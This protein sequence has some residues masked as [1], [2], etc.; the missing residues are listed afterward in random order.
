MVRPRLMLC[1]AAI[2]VALLGVGCVEASSSPEPSGV[3]RAPSGVWEITVPEPLTVPIDSE[4]GQQVSSVVGEMSSRR[5]LPLAFETFR[6]TWPEDRSSWI[7]VSVLRRPSTVTLSELYAPV[8]EGR[9]SSGPAIVRA[10][11]IAEIP[12]LVYD[13][14][15]PYPT[16]L[17]VTER[18]GFVIDFFVV[19]RH[20]DDASIQAQVAEMV[21]SFRVHR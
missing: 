18:S 20:G 3:V 10:L 15:G 4:S 21:E 6:A 5:A 19:R 16:V 17:L 12:F 8:A 11:T 1:G 2:A 9:Q 14:P 13:I 7:A